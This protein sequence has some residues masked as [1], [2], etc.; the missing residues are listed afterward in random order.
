MKGDSTLF[1]RRDETEAA[2]RPMTRILEGWSE[3]PPPSFPNYE[4]GTWGPAEA[5]AFIQ[6]DG[7]QWR[8]P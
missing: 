6:R 8:R 2:W 1:I 3:A 7:R 5:E 4:A